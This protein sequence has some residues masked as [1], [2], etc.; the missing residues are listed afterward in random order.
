MDASQKGTAEKRFIVAWFIWAAM[1][2]SLGIYILICNVI[3]DD[4]VRRPL[5]PDFSL[6][7]LRKLFY[8]LSAAALIAVHFIRKFNGVGVSH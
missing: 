3:G 6:A 7:L 1:I 4:V 8:G 2:G 5:G